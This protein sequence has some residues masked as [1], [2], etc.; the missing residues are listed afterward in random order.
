[1][2]ES[3]QKKVCVGMWASVIEGELSLLRLGK[4]IT[5][6]TGGFVLVTN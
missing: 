5:L 3:S 1:M 6:Q 4:L 2:R